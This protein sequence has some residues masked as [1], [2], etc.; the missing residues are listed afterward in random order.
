MTTTP[1]SVTAQVQDNGSTAWALAGELDLDTAM[2]IEPQLMSATSRRGSDVV[3]D[4]AGLTFCDTAGAEL[5]L[6][7]QRRCATDGGRLSLRRVPHR[8]GRVLR[9][10]GVDRVVRCTFA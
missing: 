1:I 10:L 3:V 7:L 5:F 8:T 6:R 9:V 4:L 2:R